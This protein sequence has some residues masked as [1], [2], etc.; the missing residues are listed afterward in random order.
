M[1]LRTAPVAYGSSP[2]RRQIGATADTAGLHH[3]NITASYS[4]TH[5]NARFLTHYKARDQ[6]AYS[7]ILVRFISISAVPQQEPGFKCLNV[8][9]LLIYLFH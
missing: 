4:T 3:S 9:I 7:W 1:L 6:T 8:F 5:G 2:A